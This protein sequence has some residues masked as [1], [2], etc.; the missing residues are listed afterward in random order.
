MFQFMKSVVAGFQ[1]Q[2]KATSPTPRHAS[3]RLLCLEERQ[4]M[5]AS[6]LMVV[7]APVY[8][9]VALIQPQTTNK[10]L[11]IVSSDTYTPL[12][13]PPSLVEFP[14]SAT[15]NPLDTPPS[16][17]WSHATDTYNP[18]YAPYLVTF[19]ADF[20]DRSF[21]MRG[22]N[23]TSH[24]LTILTQEY[25]ADGSAVITGA[26]D[27]LHSPAAVVTGVLNVNGADT[28][29]SFTWGDHRFDGTLSGS[30]GSYHIDGRVYGFGSKPG[31]PGHT[32]GDEAPAIPHFVDSYYD[33]TSTS[34]GHKHSFQILSETD[35]YNGTATFTGMWDGETPMTGAMYYDAQGNVRIS[36]TWQ[37]HGAYHRFDG[38][39]TH[40]PYTI[41][42][43]IS[44]LVTVDGNPNMG[45]GYVTGSERLPS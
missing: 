29:I 45:P 11:V 17:V 42:A 28:A 15:Y 18:D 38:T 6:P 1:G 4:V 9:N 19:V 44:G 26:W 20:H 39:I 23:G 31:G 41:G 14:S 12:D 5:S 3:L 33:L 21:T 25:Q 7:A 30:P 13:T 34:N 36:F 16:V 27:G 35:Q 8:S 43:S 22:Q 40:D 24:Q 32:V 37:N 2:Q 10:S